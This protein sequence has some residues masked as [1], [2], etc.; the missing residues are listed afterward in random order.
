MRDILGEDSE[1]ESDEEAEE[2]GGE[3]G[4][5]PRLKAFARLKST[6]HP[7]LQPQKTKQQPPNQKSQNL[8]PQP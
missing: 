1:G 7:K 5:R 2:D 8:N 6:Q 4:K 3:G